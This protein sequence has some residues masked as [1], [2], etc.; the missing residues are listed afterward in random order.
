MHDETY[1]ELSRGEVTRRA[2]WLWRDA[3]CPAGRDL[4]YWLQAEV[5]LLRARVPNLQSNLVRGSRPATNTTRAAILRPV[6]FEAA[7]PELGRNG[8]KWTRAA[9]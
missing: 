8:S 6:E 9:A 1:I 3:G 2:R 4:E 5:E 7:K